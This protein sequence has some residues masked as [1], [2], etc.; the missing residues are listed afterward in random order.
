MKVSVCNMKNFSFIGFLL[1]AIL[2]LP[3]CYAEDCHDAGTGG[4]I[5]VQ[6]V[7]ME[8]GAKN[9]TIQPD[10]AV[11]VY[12]FY[13]NERTSPAYFNI[14]CESNIV[15]K[16]RSYWG[17]V[18][19]GFKNENGC[20]IY[21]TNVQGV[22]FVITLDTVNRCSSRGVPGEYDTNSKTYGSKQRVNLELYII[23]K[24][25]NGTLTSGI[26][27]DQYMENNAQ[28]IAQDYLG[29]PINIVVAGC[30][31]TSENIN[32]PMGDIPVG[33]FTGPGKTVGDRDFN[34]GFACATGVGVDAPTVSLDGPQS[35]ETTDN[36]V[37]A[38]TD[39]GGEGTASGVGVQIIY[40]SEPI[41]MN[42]GEVSL[43][44][45][46]S[47]GTTETYSFRARYFQTKETVTPGLANATATLNI[48]YQ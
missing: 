39:E 7:T 33:E 3:K 21:K 31:I 17:S 30:S 37:L 22:G 32:V 9:I 15:F 26:F 8:S 5:A 29:G 28:A 35:S 40:N 1:L 41:V 12:P 24:V 18:D 4:A 27:S 23:G 47:A 10:A 45:P 14:V 42:G 11:S 43:M 2:L 19:S 46:V 34:V 20:T 44:H 36:T 6:T 25:K 48:T 16:N 13:S 38:L